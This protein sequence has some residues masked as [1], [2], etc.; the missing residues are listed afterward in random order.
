MIVYKTKDGETFLLLKLVRSVVS[1][2]PYVNK[3]NCAGG[4][5]Q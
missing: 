2:E 4:T 5:A 1:D 3:K